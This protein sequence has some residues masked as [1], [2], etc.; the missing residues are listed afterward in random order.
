MDDGRTTPCC[1]IFLRVSVGFGLLVLPMSPSVWKLFLQAFFD[2]GMGFPQHESVPGLIERLRSILGSFVLQLLDPSLSICDP[3]CF[4][5]TLFLLV[6]AIVR[7]VL[8]RRDVVR[9]SYR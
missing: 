8:H 7:L 6:F 1:P 9:F 2:I 3:K 5:L 4:P